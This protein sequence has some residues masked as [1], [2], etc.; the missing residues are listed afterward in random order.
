MVQS[1][2]MTTTVVR[3]TRTTSGRWYYIISDY[4]DSSVM[5]DNNGRQI[6][7]AFGSPKSIIKLVIKIV[8]VVSLINAVS[9]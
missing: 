3:L 1:K 5:V 8:K 9:P 4:V 6:D 2:S 7:L